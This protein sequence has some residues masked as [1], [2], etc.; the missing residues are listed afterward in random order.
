MNSTPWFIA[1]SVSALVAIGLFSSFLDD[2]ARI[3]EADRIV[4]DIRNTGD[5]YAIE[6]ADSWSAA[7]NGE[8]VTRRHLQDLDM[9]RTAISAEPRIAA[10]YTTRMVGEIQADYRCMARIRDAAKDLA[11]QRAG[12]GN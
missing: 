9:V 8:H 7:M 1:A 12:Q 5:S 2:H 6:L 11:A 3:A 4:A 10:C